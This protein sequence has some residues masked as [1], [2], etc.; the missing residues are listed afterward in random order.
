M[1]KGG[2]AM[3][4][5]YK[6]TLLTTMAV[7]AWKVWKIEQLYESG[8]KE[9]NHESYKPSANFIASMYS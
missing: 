5:L 2:Q 7:V 3:N 4:K 6:I 1:N 9:I 8:Y